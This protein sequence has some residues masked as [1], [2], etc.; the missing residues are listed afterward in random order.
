[1]VMFENQIPR[2]EVDHYGQIG[3]GIIKAMKA[4]EFEYVY[5]E[6]RVPR[7]VLN[8]VIDAFEER[9]WSMVYKLVGG[10]IEFTWGSEDM[11][12]LPDGCDDG[13]ERW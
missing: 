4:G 8:R 6:R 11:Y 10:A 12:Y 2:P 7:H 9:Q 1:M 5:E 3:Y 13:K